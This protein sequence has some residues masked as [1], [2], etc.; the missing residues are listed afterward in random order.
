MKT[1]SLFV[2][3]P[4]CIV[5]L[6][7]PVHAQD[8][9][10]PAQPAMNMEMDTQ[11]SRMHE[12]MSAAQGQMNRF[13]ATT[14]PKERRMLMQ[15]HMQTMQDS[16]KLMH[17]MTGP[18]KMGS[19]QAADLQVPPGKPMAGGEMRNHHEMMQRHMQV[20]QMVLELMVQ[21]DQMMMESIFT[22]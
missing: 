4:V 5:S 2:V 11:M 16:M 19:S 9:T 1:A 20:M 13:R 12:N 3:I 14:D 21:Q 7:A 18:M 15:D 10:A 17:G 6:V 8:Q 22:K